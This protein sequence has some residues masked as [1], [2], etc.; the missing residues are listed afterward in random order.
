MSEPEKIEV[1]EEVKDEKPIPKDK[2]VLGKLFILL[3]VNF[4]P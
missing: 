1:K 4:T 3:S 2:E